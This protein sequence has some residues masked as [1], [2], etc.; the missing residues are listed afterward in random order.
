MN[1]DTLSMRSKSVLGSDEGDP[2]VYRNRAMITGAVVG[3]SFGLYYGFVKKK[4][5][6]VMTIGG[7]VVGVILTRLLTPS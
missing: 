6:A 7:M 5:I 2:T 4:N 1:A 3:G